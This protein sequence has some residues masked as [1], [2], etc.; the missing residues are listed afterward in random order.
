[1]SNEEITRLEIYSR[2]KLTPGNKV[3]QI[4]TGDLGW[5]ISMKQMREMIFE[6]MFTDGRLGYF[7]ATEIQAA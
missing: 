4:S 5:V 3:Q 6:V 2:I 1:M 7:R